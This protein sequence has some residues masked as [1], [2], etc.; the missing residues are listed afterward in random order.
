[1]KACLIFTQ[2]SSAFLLIQLLPIHTLNFLLLLDMVTHAC[3]PGTWEVEAG[4]SGAQDLLHIHMQFK[5]SLGY[6]KPCL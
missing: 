3:D 5:A 2:L 6:I 1:M 4:G